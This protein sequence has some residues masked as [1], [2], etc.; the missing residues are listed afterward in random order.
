MNEMKE[1][2]ENVRNGM[3]YN[4]VESSYWA[5]QNEKE[6][7]QRQSKVFV[8]NGRNRDSVREGERNELIVKEEIPVNR[9][10]GWWSDFAGHAKHPF[11]CFLPCAFDMASLDVP[12]TE[13]D[14][15]MGHN[16]NIIL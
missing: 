4:Q 12:H 5:R 13:H 16:H 1:S 14:T 10:L 15:A 3:H 8:P 2:R 6:K 7:M 11:E 9:L